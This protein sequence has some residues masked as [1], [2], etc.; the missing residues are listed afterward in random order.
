MDLLNAFTQRNLVLLFHL[1][2]K[3]QGYPNEKDTPRYTVAHLYHVIKEG[4]N[5]EE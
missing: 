1:A 5:V 4:K 2:S 3:G